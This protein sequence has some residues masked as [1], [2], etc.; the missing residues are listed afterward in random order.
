M[1]EAR[2]LFLCTHDSACSQMAEG[3]RRRLETWLAARPAG[4][5]A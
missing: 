3:L 1:S 4:A 2:V 5:R